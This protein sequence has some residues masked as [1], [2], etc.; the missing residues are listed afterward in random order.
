MYVPQR[1]KFEQCV[2]HFLLR[3][4]SFPTVLQAWGWSIDHESQ[5]I[6]VTNQPKITRHA[7]YT[8]KKTSIALYKGPIRAMEAIGSTNLENEYFKKEWFFS[9]GSTGWNFKQC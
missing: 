4:S 2:V 8:E 5:T 6:T 7:Y 3:Q 9:K 1:L